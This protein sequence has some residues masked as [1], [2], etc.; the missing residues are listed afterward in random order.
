MVDGLQQ[1]LVC[2]MDGDVEAAQSM[3]AQV[4]TTT[5]EDPSADAG[6]AICAILQKDLAVAEDLTERVLAVPDAPALAYLAQ[7]MLA[8]SRGDLEG[9]SLDF[10]KALETDPNS[11]YGRYVLGTFLSK[12]QDF[13]AAVRMLRPV[14]QERAEFWRARRNLAISYENTGAHDLALREAMAVARI[15]PS[16]GNLRL[17]V[18]IAIARY[19][20]FRWIPLAVTVIFVVGFANSV[21]AFIVAMTVCSAVCFL[22]YWATLRRLYLTLTFLTWG[23]G[24]IYYAVYLS[25]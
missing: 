14:V 6:L 10:R 17:L 5:P 24:A 12:P 22:T 16:T 23:L 19:R 3:F 21:V 11:A 4:H 8:E 18:S 13:S 20:F 7:G 9:A 2:L 15:K 25:H 1:A